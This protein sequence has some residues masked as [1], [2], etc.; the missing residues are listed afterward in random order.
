MNGVCGS[1]VTTSYLAPSQSMVLC[2]E[3]ITRKCAR[4]YAVLSILLSGVIQSLGIV[5]HLMCCTVEDGI[6]RSSL[7]SVMFGSIIM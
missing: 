5:V 6:E 1:H 3:L 7:L 4:P 2:A